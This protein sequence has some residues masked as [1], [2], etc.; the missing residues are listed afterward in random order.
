MQLDDVV[1]PQAAEAV[2]CRELQGESQ[3]A[4]LA[5]DIASFTG[6]GDLITLS[7]DLG[8]GKTAFARAL[9]RLLTGEPDLEV[10]SPAFTLMQSYE[11]INFPVLHA[12]FYRI[13]R[14]G[15]I[16]ELGFEEAGQG[17]LVLVEWP[18]RAGDFL[19]CS[20]LDIAFS[21]DANRGIEYRTVTLTGSGSFAA[22]L[23]HAK[24]VHEI[25]EQSGWRGAERE[26]MQ[27][28][29]ST[30]SYLRLIKPDGQTAILMY[31]LPRADGPPIRYGKSYSAIAKLAENIRPFVAI[32]R[33]LRA[34]G[35]SSPQIYACDLQAGLAIIED[36]GS[37]PVTAEGHAIEERFAV[38]LAALAH[39]HAAALPE[40]LPI[41]DGSLTISEYD[42]D[43]LLIEVELLLDWYAPYFA[44]AQLSSTAKAAFLNLWRQALQEILSPPH[45]WT[46]RDYHSP[47][48][49]W[50]PERE[51]IAKV[52][53][54]D[55]QDCVLGHPAYDVVSLLQDARVSVPQEL[56][57][58][59]LAYYARLRR[60]PDPGFDVASFLRAYAIFG[61]Q[62]ATK[63]L[64]IFA[65]LDERDRKP[66]YLAHMPRVEKYLTLDLRHPALT[67]L[68]HWYG[69]HLPRILAGESQAQAAE[70]D[71][72]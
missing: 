45:V 59:L 9:I 19:S 58:K 57:M 51:G 72:T 69:K 41:E 42:I 68:A 24:T 33:R 32:A 62:R 34:E 66:Q 61:A 56:E 71:G 27:G 65:R 12:D 2:W 54:L 23:G 11:G 10:P 22:R 44:C 37:E 64:G 60:E 35:L 29:A 14:P 8:T 48:L 21:L 5:A 26:E 16:G 15:D 31:S 36:L 55:F 25:L 70:D 17:A 46:L 28:D 7:G 30:R 38:A 39:I 47:N 18:E 13:E 53:I 43:A 3:I 49:L 1:Q 20:K 40:S 6:A 50:L 63:I 67:E 4:E 52:G